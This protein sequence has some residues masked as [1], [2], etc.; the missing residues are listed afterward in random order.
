MG[1]SLG[2][3]VARVAGQAQQASN[4]TAFGT[5]YQAPAATPY[6]PQMPFQ[7]L[8]PSPLVQQMM[9]QRA[10]PLRGLGALNSL[11]IGFTPRTMQSLPPMPQY[12]I[13]AYRPNMAPAQT[14]LNRVAVSVAEQQRRAV[15]AEA[16]RLRAE[17]EALR[18]QQQ[19]QQQQQNHL[20]WG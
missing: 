19:Q 18:Q 6:N 1:G 17:N 10:Q 8:P 9:A 11:G 2:P 4:P 15:Q 14:S 7:G 3:V 13:P 16:D 5:Q 20:S 12:T